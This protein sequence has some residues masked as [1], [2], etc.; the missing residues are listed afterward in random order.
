MSSKH[1][2][3]ELLQYIERALLLPLPL[4]LLRIHST[5][6]HRQQR[7]DPTGPI[8]RVMKDIPA[9][10]PPPPQLA[11]L[12]PCLTLAPALLL[13]IL[14]YGGCRAL[15]TPGKEGGKLA[16]QA[17]LA[18]AGIDEQDWEPVLQ[19][20]KFLLLQI[21]FSPFEMRKERLEP[22]GFTDTHLAILGQALKRAAMYCKL[23]YKRQLSP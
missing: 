2:R 18:A 11:P 15:D 17:T 4:P 16:I 12:L 1:R 7:V 10:Q 5:A 9:G 6:R 13:E 3:R 23:Q 22:A 14:E 8:Y 19:A 21:A 20:S